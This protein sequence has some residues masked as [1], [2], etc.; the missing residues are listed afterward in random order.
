MPAS[1]GNSKDDEERIPIIILMARQFGLDIG[2]EAIEEQHHEQ[3]LT[4][5]DCTTYQ[6]YRFGRPMP[7]AEFSS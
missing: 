4:G 5:L 7:M 2:T 3:F 1:C 6:G